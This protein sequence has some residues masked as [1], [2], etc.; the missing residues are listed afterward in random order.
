MR[1]D[2][3]IKLYKEKCLEFNQAYEKRN[4]F[5][6]PYID[7]MLAGIELIMCNNELYFMRLHDYKSETEISR[8]T[9]MNVFY[10]NKLYYSCDL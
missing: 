8:I 2:D 6:I 1:L 3:A 10:C 4:M 9:H 7:G 5:A